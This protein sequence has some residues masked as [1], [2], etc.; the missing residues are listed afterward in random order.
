MSFQPGSR[1]RRGGTLKTITYSFD[2]FNAL[3]YAGGGGPAALA[4]GFF[5]GVHRG[6]AAVISAAAKKGLKTVVVTFDH[7]PGKTEG[8]RPVPEITSRALKERILASLSVDD[9]VYL[10]FAR[11]RDM[12]PERFIG[13]LC[14][15]YRISYIGSGFNY[16]FGRGASAGAGELEKLCI[17][18]GIEVGATAPVCVGG[19]PLS[20]TRIRSLIADGCVKEAAE[21]LGRPFGILG[22]VVH[23]RKLGRTLGIPTINQPLPPPQLLP[24]F[25]VYASVAHVGGKRYAAVTNVGVK[26]TVADGLAAGAETYIIGF[27]GDLYGE[28]IKVDLVDF[29]RPEQKFGG[30]E[31]LRIQME[32]DAQ[33]A[34]K[35]LL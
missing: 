7:S 14:E 34:G 26:P 29:I 33:K 30:I 19:L 20:S 31:E 28:V 32:N 35:I 21:L 18:R 16:R 2:E 1:H 6:H 25:G 27:E 3:P 12:E 22:E 10:D 4:L 24:R 5:D 23:G 15:K 13:L 17:E 11:V 8:G 9:V